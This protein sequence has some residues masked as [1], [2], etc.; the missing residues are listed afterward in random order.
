[1][2]ARIY[3]ARATLISM[4]AEK[5]RKTTNFRGI[6]SHMIFDASCHIFFF[7]SR[8]AH[9]LSCCIISFDMKIDGRKPTIQPYQR[10]QK[11]KHTNFRKLYQL[12]E[13]LF[14]LS[15]RTPLAQIEYIHTDSCH[16][17]LTAK[18]RQ[19][20]WLNQ[21]IDWL[22]VMR[23]CANNHLNYYKHLDWIWQRNFSHFW[24]MNK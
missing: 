24:R 11:E 14:Y 10:Q 16:T 5:F 3:T 22:F 18:S 2:H 9:L 17:G 15:K 23:T 21:S 4:H 8:H 7:H 19:K 12:C 1:M 20:K 13:R 6:S